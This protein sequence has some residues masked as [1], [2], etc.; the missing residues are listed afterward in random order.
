M[1][2]VSRGLVDKVANALSWCCWRPIAQVDRQRLAGDDR[3]ENDKNPVIALRE[4][5]EDHTGRRH[6]RGPH[7]LDPEERR[8]R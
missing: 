6:A 7:P 1:A 2:R 4:I 8:G 3:S 5:A